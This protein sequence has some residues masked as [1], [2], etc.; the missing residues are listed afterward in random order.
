MT[1]GP[2]SRVYWKV[3]DD[4]KFD[5][6]RCDMRH[7]GSWTLMLVIADMAYPAPAF[8]PPSVSK[9]SLAALVDAKL[10]ELLP[11]RMYRVKG[12][13]SER[14]SRSERGKAGAAARWQ[15]N[16]TAMRPQSDGNAT[17]MLD[18]TSIEETR[19]EETDTAREDEAVNENDLFAFIAQHG[20]FIRPDSGFGIRLLGLVDR[21]GAEV[22]LEKA[23]AMV[24]DEPLSDRQWVF[25]LEK[26]LEAI[27]SPPMD[28][29]PV[30]D[31]KPSPVFERMYARRLERYRETGVWPEDWGPAPTGAA[32]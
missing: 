8:V 28:E 14:E 23:R 13:R 4:K 29:L 21:R 20:A 19:Q 18:E 11:A 12:L 25:G 7:F 6:I 24:T 1:D 26:A 9:A 22:V 32:A 2:Y 16:A 30:E 5:A 27:P 17:G 3:L 31:P 15:G 10:V